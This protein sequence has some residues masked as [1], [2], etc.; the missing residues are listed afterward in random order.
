MEFNDETNYQGISQDARQLV[1]LAVNDTTSLP[2][3]TILRSV[4]AM[5]KKVNQKIWENTGLW[6]YDDSNYTD[7]PTATTDLV[8][9]QQ[10][11]QLP[12][13]AQ[14]IDRVEVMDNSGIYR[15]L[16]PID[17]SMVQGQA[18]S[19]FQDP[20]GVGGMPIYYDMVGNSIML[21][22]KPATAY[23]TTTKGLK[24]YFTREIHEF[25][26]TDTN[27][28]AGFLDDFHRILSYGAAYDY[29][30]IA[31]LTERETQ[32]EKQ[33]TD[34][35]SSIESFY[36]MRHRELKPKIRPRIQSNI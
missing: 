16:Y 12:S 11:Y 30:I 22:P 7:F 23:I 24:L 2:T 27:S 17:K 36:G 32:Y 9:L 26:I 18:M 31:G 8:D 28:E 5:Y 29:S 34:M 25:T 10:D 15:K 3:S 14:K 6:E 1:G 19:E 20:E 35:M 33:I 21:Y 13:T 4:N